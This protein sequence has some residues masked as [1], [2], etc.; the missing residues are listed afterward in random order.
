MPLLD[1]A[2]L[3][4]AVKELA[5]YHLPIWTLHERKHL[6]HAARVWLRKRETLHY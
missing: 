4:Y 6:I 3:I 2:L 5:A 1:N